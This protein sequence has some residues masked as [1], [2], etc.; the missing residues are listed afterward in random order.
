MD[1]QPS[2]HPKWHEI[3]HMWC[4]TVQGLL[5]GPLLFSVYTRDVPS[6]VEPAKSIQFADDIEIQ[7]SHTSTD[8]ISANLSTAVT[9]LSDWLRQRGLILNETKSHLLALLSSSVC[10]TQTANTTDQSHLRQNTPPRSLLSQVSRSDRGQHFD[11][12]GAH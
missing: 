1:C 9:K 5:L 7:F 2:Q 6:V 10:R 3:V 8:V 12:Q 4:S 11:I